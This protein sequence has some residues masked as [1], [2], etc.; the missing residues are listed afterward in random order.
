MVNGGLDCSDCHGDM[1]TL[2]DPVS[3]S[4]IEWLTM[5][6]CMDCHEERQVSNDCLVC[7]K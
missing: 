1:T 4:Q 6:A 3:R 5:K 7:H 2:D